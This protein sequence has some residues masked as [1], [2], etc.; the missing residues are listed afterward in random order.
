LLEL[1]ADPTLCDGLHGGDP[2]G[3][4]ELSCHTTLAELGR[5]RSR[6]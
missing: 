5:L 2:A 3:W 1:G 6:P 4:A